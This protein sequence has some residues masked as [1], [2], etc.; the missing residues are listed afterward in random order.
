M[1]NQ[2]HIKS[3]IWIIKDDHTFLGEGRVELLANID[4]LGSINKAA[5]AMKMSYQK[6]WKMIDS[7][8]ADANNPL[9][10]K[11]SGGKQGGGTILTPY[12]KK[13]L[14]LFKTLQKKQ[15]TFLTKELKKL[16]F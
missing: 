15:H 14:K 10:I 9:V 2:Y 4:I 7:M 3:R 11:T 5:K 12:G 13:V 16:E 1:N 8:N 6:A